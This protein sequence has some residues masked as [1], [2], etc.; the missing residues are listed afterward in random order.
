VGM[1]APGE[2]FLFGNDKMLDPRVSCIISQASHALTLA[3]GPPSVLRYYVVWLARHFSPTTRAIVAVANVPFPSLLLR[4]AS[5]LDP[6][7][8]ESYFIASCWRDLLNPPS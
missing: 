8:C 7:E 4:K 3:V 6:L 1:V 5:H 2:Q